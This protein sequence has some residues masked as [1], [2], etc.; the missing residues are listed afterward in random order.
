[1]KTKYLVNKISPLILLCLVSIQSFPSSYDWQHSNLEDEGLNNSKIK[2]LS[3]EFRN[4]IHGYVDAFLL[5]KNGKIVHEEYY[6]NDYSKLTKNLKLEQSKIM[7]KNYG[8][9]SYTHLTLPT[10]RIV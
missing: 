1:M 6:K 7:S 8:A 3:D 10:K 2:I 4:G 5:I 9:V